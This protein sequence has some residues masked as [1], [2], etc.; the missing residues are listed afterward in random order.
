MFLFLQFTTNNIHY[1]QLII[2]Y[3]SKFFPFSIAFQEFLLTTYSNFK[4]HFL[5]FKFFLLD[6]NL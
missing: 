4:F 2:N 3:P 6:L 5:D 1:T